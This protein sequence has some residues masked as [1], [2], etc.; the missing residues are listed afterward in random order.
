MAKTDEVK[1]KD[2]KSQATTNKPNVQQ[3]KE[4]LSDNTG[5]RRYDPLGIN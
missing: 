5:W 2:P 4:R 3:R 1:N